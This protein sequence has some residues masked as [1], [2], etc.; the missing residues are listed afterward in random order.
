MSELGTISTMIESSIH[1]YIVGLVISM[2]STLLRDGG[3]L[4]LESYREEHREN[5]DGRVYVVD[6]GG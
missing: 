1:V 4:F 3:L 2:C 6:N 5:G